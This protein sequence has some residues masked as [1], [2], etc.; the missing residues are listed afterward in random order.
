MHVV[1][2][3]DCTLYRVPVHTGS[4]QLSVYDKHDLNDRISCVRL[5]VYIESG[6]CMIRTL[7][8]NKYSTAPGTCA[9][10]HDAPT[11]EDAATYVQYEAV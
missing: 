3:G 9:L 10:L 11:M 7:R 6:H 1:F 5:I 2:P 4:F 8:E